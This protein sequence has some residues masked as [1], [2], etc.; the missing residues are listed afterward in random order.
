LLTDDEW[1]QI[2]QFLKEPLM[3]LSGP[4][5]TVTNRADESIVVDPDA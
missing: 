4:Q 1:I 3:F 2:K 5:S